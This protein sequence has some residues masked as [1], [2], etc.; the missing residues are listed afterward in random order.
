MLCV[1]TDARLMAGKVFVAWT[2]ARLVLVWD[3]CICSKLSAV[4]QGLVRQVW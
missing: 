1:G 3:V 4:V 2:Y